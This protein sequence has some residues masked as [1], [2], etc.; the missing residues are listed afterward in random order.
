MPKLIYWDDDE[1][2]VLSEEMIEEWKNVPRWKIKEGVLLAFGRDPEP[3]AKLPLAIERYILMATE[4]FQ[5]RYPYGNIPP[6]DFIEWAEMNGLRFDPK[7]KKGLNIK[8]WEASYHAKSQEYKALEEECGR[9]KAQ[10]ETAHNAN[11]EMS[12]LR[13]K[14]YQKLCLGL[15]ISKYR[16]EPSAKKS[17]AVKNIADALAEHGLDLNETTVRDILADS[18]NELGFNNAE[19]QREA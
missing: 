8:D 15:A 10:I 4:A 3:N 9:L 12:P 5:E 19:K 11:K 13:K 2:W 1:V 14:S 7:F 16:Y 17:T 6:K 18:A